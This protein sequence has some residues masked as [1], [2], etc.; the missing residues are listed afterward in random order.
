MAS[1]VYNSCIRNAV[2][3][4]I[5]F[6][7]DTFYMM[8]VTSTYTPDQD[9]HLDRA[10]VTNEVTGTNY[11]SAGQAVTVTVGAVDTA[12][13]RVDISFA[14]VTW[15]SSTITAAAAV[16]YKS[17]GTAA[18]DL[19]VAY[20]DFGGDVSSTSGDFTVSTTTPLRFANS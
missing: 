13:D 3:G 19:L 9:T 20:L 5:D 6:D 12:N 16:V 10:D 7:T 4:Q 11:T 15:A 17:T 18:D 1:L 2:T 14:D 8:L